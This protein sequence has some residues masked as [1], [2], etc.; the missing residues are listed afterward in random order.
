MF[1]FL[2]KLSNT[3]IAIKCKV[4]LAFRSHGS[5]RPNVLASNNRIYFI[6]HFQLKLSPTW[7]EV[8]FSDVSSMLLDITKL[9]KCY[10]CTSQNCSLPGETC[11]IWSGF[12][13]PLLP[14]IIEGS[15]GKIKIRLGDFFLAVFFYL[16]I[17]PAYLSF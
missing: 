9:N 13:W 6:P 17:F 16:F 11:H 1:I 3:R 8:S 7:M 15:L 2:L 5:T 14:K 10:D 4:V 12:T